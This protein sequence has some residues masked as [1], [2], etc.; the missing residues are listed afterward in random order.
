MLGVARVERGDRLVGQD[1]LRLLHQRAADRHALLLAA[2]QMVGAARREH[3]HIELIQRGERDAAI[4]A[5]PGLQRGA[6]ERRVGQPAEQHVVQ[7]VEP[8]DQ[9]ELLED[10]GAAPAPVA[11]LAAGQCP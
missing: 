10:H 11:Q 7:H 3:C 2:G 6:P 9:V 8:A 1:D 5:R 4:L